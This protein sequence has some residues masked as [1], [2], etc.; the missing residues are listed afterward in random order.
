MIFRSRE[1][2]IMASSEA[3]TIDANIVRTPSGNSAA[4][5]GAS[6]WMSIDAA[7]IARRV[8]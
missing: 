2:L 8:R 5:I 1:T 4:A 6:P 7:V 3:L